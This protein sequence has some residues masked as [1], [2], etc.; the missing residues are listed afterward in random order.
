MQLLIIEPQNIEQGMSNVEV[1][2][3][4]S[5][6]RYSLFDIRYLYFK[7]ATYNSQNHLSTQKQYDS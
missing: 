6:V 2:F 5:A 3:P 4:T 1:F 7:L